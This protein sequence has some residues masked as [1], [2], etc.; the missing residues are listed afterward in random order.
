MAKDTSSKPSTPAKPTTP[1]SRPLGDAGA[2]EVETG[3]GGNGAFEKVLS[4]SAKRKAKAAA[5]AA[6]KAGEKTGASNGKLKRL[7]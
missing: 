4:K 5:K 1:Y 6:A 3:E 2:A 7:R